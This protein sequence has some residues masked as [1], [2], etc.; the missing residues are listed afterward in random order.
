MLINSIRH[1]LPALASGA[2]R[3]AARGRVSHAARG[4]RLG[5]RPLRPHE[6]H[7][8]T[9]APR[10][11]LATLT[12]LADKMTVLMFF[13]CIIGLLDIIYFATDTANRCLSLWRP[14]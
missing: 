9:W 13:L 11:P 8:R 10:T 7:R 12:L 4:V 3:V 1:H 14:L 2:R 5:H 6:G